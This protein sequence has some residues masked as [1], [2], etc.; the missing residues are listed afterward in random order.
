MKALTNLRFPIGDG[1]VEVLV[2]ES[3]NKIGVNTAASSPNQLLNAKPRSIGRTQS[4]C[5]IRTVL[6]TILLTYVV[7]NGC[8]SYPNL[9]GRWS[10]RWREYTRDRTYVHGSAWK[11]VQQ[12]RSRHQLVT[13][14]THEGF[15]M[16]L[17]PQ[18]RPPYSPRSRICDAVLS[19][20]M[21]RET[22]LKA[23]EDTVQHWRTVAP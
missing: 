11:V 9:I 18:R 2:I 7:Q 6:V 19:E 1:A 15:S 17:S 3:P 22:T 13:W 12:L 20:P 4:F 21:Y 23:A 8:H 5:V 10:G 14:M 16:L